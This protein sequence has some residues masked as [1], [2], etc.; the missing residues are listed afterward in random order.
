MTV[1]DGLNILMHI[2]LLT[3][4]YRYIYIQFTFVFLVEFHASL[5]YINP[6]LNYSSRI[7]LG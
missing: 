7:Q 4:R 6:N 5:T 2:L 1:V 3:D